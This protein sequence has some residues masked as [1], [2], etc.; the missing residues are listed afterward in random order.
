MITIP[1][2]NELYED[3]LDD[4]ESQYTSSIPL[5]GKVFLRAVAK[6]QAAKLKLYYL[7]TGFLQ[8]NIFV[9]TADRESAG[10]TLERF[11][12]VKL[13]RDPNPAVA[14]EYSCGVLGTAGSVISAGTTFKSS[15]NSTSPGKL[16]V[17]DADFT[18]TV[19][20]VSFPATDNITLRALEGGTD[21]KLSVNDQL[22]ATVPI[23][24]VEKTVVVVSETTAPID[25]ED[26]EEYRRKVIDAYQ[27][28][29]QGGAAT[30][31][32]LWSYDADGVQQVYPYAKDGASNEI[33]VFVE[34]TT[35]D[36]TDGK[37][38]PSSTILSD[39]ESVIEFDPDTTKPLNERGRR[40][41]G[42]FDVHVLAITVKEVDIEI[43]SFVDLTAAKQTAILASITETVNAIR[44]FVA[45]ADVLENKNDILDVNKITSAI[46]LAVP[47][48]SFGSVVLKIDTVS[49]STYTFE[50]G[51]IPYLNS[52]TYT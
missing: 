20:D 45:A 15:A 25:E 29:P 37:G 4:L 51:D 41:L 26:I 28:E 23:A 50:N 1:T 31:Y 40:P 49:V 14:G 24:G 42:V 48:S 21:S 22:I 3:I 30:D 17:I 33:N 35:A 9:D 43:P 16:F 7:V 13:N 2:L 8:K 27:L 34:A 44:P 5:F 39:V 12:R 6:V 11:G 36:S 32:R 10:G 52:V 19:T 46:L 47:G 38:T 18:L